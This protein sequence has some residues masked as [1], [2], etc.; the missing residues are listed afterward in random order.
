MIMEE[1][2]TI[3]GLGC[4]AVSKII[5]PQTGRNTRWPNPKDPK[6]YIDTYESMIQKKIDD[7]NR[8]YGFKQERLTKN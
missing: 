4:G 3:I 6:T 7:L 8:L 2:Q 5:P 1:A